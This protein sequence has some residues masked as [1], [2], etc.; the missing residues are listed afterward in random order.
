LKEEKAVFKDM[1]KA[2][3]YPSSNV[4]RKSATNALIDLQH[5]SAQQGDKRIG[6][7]R[8]DN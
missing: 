3:D 6:D 1:I 7:G 5:W 4:F 2:L 8:L